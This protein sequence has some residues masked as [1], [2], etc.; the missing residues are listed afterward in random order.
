MSSHREAP[1]ISKD[2][3]ADSTDLYAF[4]SPTRP[5][6]SRSSRTTSRCRARPAGRT[7]TS[8]ATTC[9]TRSTSTTTATAKPTSRTSSGSRPRSRSAGRSSTTSG[10]ITVARQPRLEPPAVL[11]GDADRLERPA[12]EASPP[13]PPPRLLHIARS[14]LPCPPCNIG[15]LLDAELRRARRAAIQTAPRRRQGVRGPARPKASTSTSARSS[16]SATCVRSRSCTPVR[17]QRARADAP[18]PA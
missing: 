14:H 17:S 4:V 5:T 7:S 16:T 12:H 1:E 3:V 18:A 10:P 9:S 8:S 2:P 11:H 15:P 6:P 13:S